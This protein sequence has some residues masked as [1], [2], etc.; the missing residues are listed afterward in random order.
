MLD[1]LGKFRISR[2]LIQKSPEAA[3]AVLE[4]CLVVR[5]ELQWESDAIEYVALHPDFDELQPG[6]IAPTYEAIISDGRRR[7]ERQ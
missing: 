3:L 6:E 1:P 7:W 2:E 4:G 5:A